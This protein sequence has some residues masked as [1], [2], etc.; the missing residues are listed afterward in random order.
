MARKTRAKRLTQ[1]EG[2]DKCL[3]WFVTVSKAFVD[4]KSSLHMEIYFTFKQQVFTKEVAECKPHC[5]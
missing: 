2:R 5:S 4:G 3:V 1:N